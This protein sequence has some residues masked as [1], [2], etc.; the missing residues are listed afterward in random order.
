[1][2]RDTESGVKVLN[3]A[4]GI[5][6]D[7]LGGVAGGDSTDIAIRRVE[8]ATAGAVAD[9]TDLRL[10]VMDLQGRHVDTDS[11]AAWGITTDTGRMH[12]V[13]RRDGGLCP[14][15][16][17]ATRKDLGLDTL[18]PARGGYMAGT[19]LTAGVGGATPIA[20]HLATLTGQ[21]WINMGW[22]GRDSLQVASRWGALPHLTSAAKIL[23]PAGTTTLTLAWE[24]DY[25][26]RAAT[27]V[28]DNGTRIRGQITRDISDATGKTIAFTREAA[29]GGYS[30]PVG[31][32]ILEH[33]AELA[34]TPRL[35]YLVEVSRNNP[36]GQSPGVVITHL[37]AMIGAV[38][39]YTRAPRVLVMGE[40]LA[41]TD[42]AADRDARRARNTAL[43]MAFPGEYVDAF[44]WLLTDAALA[45]AGVTPTAQDNTDRAAGITPQSLRI[46][47]L[48]PNTLGNQCIAKRL[49]TAMIERGWLL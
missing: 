12:D 48:H 13:L 1:M 46:D 2:A 5:P 10:D 32:Q 43:R 33:P 41:S 15:P 6:A 40:P 44:E 36:P 26:S 23:D 31:T 27:I 19:S 8:G 47:T 18:V 35:T 29:G 21:S 11:E 22:A 4:D 34:A 45:Y 3:P 30:L 14:T 7:A 16:L 39:G 37:R 9:V 28:L 42:S 24:K 38:T 20:T 17:E 49:H 25:T